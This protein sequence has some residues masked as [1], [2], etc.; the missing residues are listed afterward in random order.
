MKTIT[1]KISGNYFNQ[2]VK[3]VYNEKFKSLQG[4][5][6]EEN[7]RRFKDLPCPRIGKVIIVK[8]TVLPKAFKDSV[9]S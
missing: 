7:I 9:Q 3:D 2:D 4:G 6:I 1:S 8:K 5:E